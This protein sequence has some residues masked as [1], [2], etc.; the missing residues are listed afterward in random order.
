[1]PLIR[2]S[3]GLPK[4]VRLAAPPDSR[5]LLLEQLAGNDVDERRR[6]ARALSSDPDAASALA[7]RLE[8][9]PEPSVREALFGSLVDIGGALA[10]NLVAPLLRSADAGLRGGAIV[11]LKDLADDAAPV[12]DALLG[13]PDPDVRILAIEVTRAWPSALAL[14]RLRRVIEHDPHVNVCGAAVDVATEV[15]TDELVAALVG[16]RAR[17]ANEPFLLFAVDIACS[18]IDAIGERSS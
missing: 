14:P 1:M 2:A 16:L 11:A 4:V 15:G 10:A 7:A 12:L 5:D 9:E 18:R 13:D 3:V 8:V 6:A 17:F